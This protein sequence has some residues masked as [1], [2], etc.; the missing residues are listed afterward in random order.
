MYYLTYWFYCYCYRSF[1]VIFLPSTG[2]IFPLV[3]NF[4]RNFSYR[5]EYLSGNSNYCYAL[6][7]PS[8]VLFLVHYW[9]W[10]VSQQTGQIQLEG[11]KEYL[12]NMITFLFSIPGIF[13]VFLKTPIAKPSRTDFS[14]LFT[15]P[16]L[17]ILEIFQR[18]IA[19]ILLICSNHVLAFVTSLV[20]IGYFFS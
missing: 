15:S 9:Q 16:S 7:K 8:L 11:S 19:D 17:L 18:T 20:R 2:V 13:V 14:P 3:F 4:W 10:Q 12:L 5:F 6:A 1:L